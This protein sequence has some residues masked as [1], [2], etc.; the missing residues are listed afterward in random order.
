MTTATRS[1]LLALRAERAAMAEGFKLLDDKRLLLAAELLRELAR[2]AGLWREF[3]A[4]GARSKEAL[5][6]AIER[7]GL[8]GLQCYP[9]ALAR[10]ARIDVREERLYGVRLQSATLAWRVDEAAAPA[11]FSPEAERCR[12]EFR[13]L[14]ERSAALAASS[15]NLRRLAAEYRKTER[16]ARALEEVLI[17]ELAARLRGIE[18]QLDESEQEDALLPRS[19]RARAAESEG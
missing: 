16:R 14:V 3:T 6:E 13:A 8:E 18:E 17:P 5:R 10:D 2:Y 11:H 9:A 15:G 19:A 1:V 4:R 12:A 7:H